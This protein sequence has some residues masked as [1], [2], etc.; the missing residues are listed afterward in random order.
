MVERTLSIIK[1]DAVRKHGIGQILA[2]LEKGGLRVVA[3]RFMR[4]SQ[5]DAA[6]FY[7]VHKERPFY[8]SLTQF[9]SSGPILVSVL[10]GENA[11]ARNREIMGATDP[12]KAAAGTIRRDFGTDVEQNAVH[13]SD[14]PDTARWEISFFFTQ[15]DQAE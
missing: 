7:A 11:I 4:L 15:L 10:E 14:G 5:A 9:M 6:R 1:P 2:R 13:G 12:A 3:S 8:T